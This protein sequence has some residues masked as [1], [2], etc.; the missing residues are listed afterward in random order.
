MAKSPPPQPHKEG[1]ETSAWDKASYGAVILAAGMS[2]RMGAN[3]LLLPWRDGLPIV[4]HVAAKFP[5]AGI[6][7]VV[8]VTGR[9]AALVEAA[10]AAFDLR[11]VHNP[12]Y[13]T[14]EMLS[15]LQV[16][17]RALP[18]GLAGAFVQPADMPC[19]PEALLGQLM[20]AHEP[21]WSLAPSYAGRRGHPVLLDRGN[22]RAMLGLGAGARPRD[23]LG[24][25]KLVDVADEGVLLDVDTRGVYERLVGRDP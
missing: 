5:R 2:S 6:S 11:C 9:D 18:G 24:R 10:L 25:V 13:A 15:S 12:R 4:A 16:G 14:G 23:G 8:V 19:V 3:K 17:L 7:P 22:W 21:G 1:G 20:A